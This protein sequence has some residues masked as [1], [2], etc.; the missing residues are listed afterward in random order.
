MDTTTGSPLKDGT[1][2]YEVERRTRYGERPGSNLRWNFMR[3]TRSS[4]RPV[5]A[6]RAAR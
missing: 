4:A 2:L 6:S 3:S 5:P 1:A